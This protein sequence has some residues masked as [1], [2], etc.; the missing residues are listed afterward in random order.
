MT[1]THLN[2]YRCIR[3][4]SGLED[5]K[6]RLHYMKTSVPWHLAEQIFFIKIIRLLGPIGVQYCTIYNLI[7][8]Q[9]QLHKTTEDNEKLQREMNVKVVEAKKRE[10]ELRDLLSKV[11]RGGGE[12]GCQLGRGEGG[13]MI[14]WERVGEM[15]N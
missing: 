2:C 3:S 5:S 14:G 1:N 12:G 9:V 10:D 7:L 11:T 8:I 13:D 15:V 6:N 4:R